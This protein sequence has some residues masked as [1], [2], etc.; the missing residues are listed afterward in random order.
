MVNID[1]VPALVRL[2]LW[3]SDVCDFGEGEGLK[4]SWTVLNRPSY[5]LREKLSPGSQG[6][7]PGENRLKQVELWGWERGSVEGHQEAD[8]PVGTQGIGMRV[9]R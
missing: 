3:H 8:I 6:R 1:K 4:N 7:A 5:D 2:I 9:V